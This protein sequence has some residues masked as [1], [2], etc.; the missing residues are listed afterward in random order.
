[1]F[2]ARCQ[3]R[4]WKRKEEDDWSEQRGENLY[5]IGNTKGSGKIIKDWCIISTNFIGKIAVIGLSIAL[6]RASLL[7]RVQTGDGVFDGKCWIRG[8]FAGKI[9]IKS[10][11]SDA[12]PPPSHEITNKCDRN[13]SQSPK[14]AKIPLITSKCCPYITVCSLMLHNPFWRIS[15]I[16]E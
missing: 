6:L 10:V 8:Q 13:S 16:T 7:W 5:L 2:A 1:M 3:A 9:L 14:K 11:I 12:T 4:V 15:I